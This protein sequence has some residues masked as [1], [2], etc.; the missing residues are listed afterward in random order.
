MRNTANTFALPPR[1]VSL[2]CAL[3]QWPAWFTGFKMFTLDLAFLSDAGDWPTILVGLVTA[4]F[5]I[6]QLDHGLFVRRNDDYM[7]QKTV[8]DERSWEKRRNFLVTIFLI[9]IAWIMGF[10]LSRGLSFSGYGGGAAFGVFF[11]IFVWNLQG[12]WV[13]PLV[14]GARE[15]LDRFTLRW[16]F[17]FVSIL[18]VIGAVSTKRSDVATRL[19]CVDDPSN[20]SDNKAKAR[21]I[22]VYS[23]GAVFLVLLFASVQLFHWVYLRRLLKTCKTTNQ[24]FKMTRCSHEFTVFLFLYLIAYLSGVNASLTMAIME[25]PEAVNG[26]SCS[27]IH[28][29]ACGFGDRYVVTDDTCLGKPVYKS[30]LVI[31]S[32]GYADHYMA[33]FNEITYFTNGATSYFVTYEHTIP[34]DKEKLLP[35]TFRPTGCGRPGRSK[36]EYNVKNGVV[37][38]VVGSGCSGCSQLISS[39]DWMC[40]YANPPTEIYPSTVRSLAGELPCF[41]WK[42]EFESELCGENCVKLANFFGWILFGFYA[43]VPLFRMATLGLS[44]KS[45]LKAEGGEYEDAFEAITVRARSESTHADFEEVDTTQ[46]LLVPIKNDR[47]GFKSRMTHLPYPIRFWKMNSDDV[48]KKDL[49][50]QVA[51]VTS[52]LS[53]FEEKWWWWKIYLLAERAVLAALVFTEMSVWAAFAVTCLGWLASFYTSPYWE[54]DEDKADLIA[55]GTTLLTVFVACLAETEVIRGDEIVVAVVLNVSALVTVVILIMAVGPRRLIMSI[56]AYYKVK[57]RQLKLQNG[58]EAADAMTE[59]EVEDMTETEFL[60]KSIAVRTRLMRR[61]QDHLVGTNFLKWV[62]SEHEEDIKSIDARQR[63]ILEKVAKQFG[64]TSCWLY[65]PGN[66]RMIGVTFEGGKATEINWRGEDLSLKEGKPI[67]KGLQNLDSCKKI[68]LSCN[69]IY[70]DFKTNKKEVMRL[71][72]KFII[73]NKQDKTTLECVAVK[74]GKTLEWLYDGH[75]AHNVEKFRGI[76]FSNDNKIVGINW[77][78]QGLK[79]QLPDKICELKDLKRLDLRFNDITVEDNDAINEMRDCS[80]PEHWDD[81]RYVRLMIESADV[82]KGMHFVK[83]KGDGKHGTKKTAPCLGHRPRIL[84]LVRP[85]PNEKDLVQIEDCNNPGVFLV[86]EELELGNDLSMGG[87]MISAKQQKSKSNYSGLHWEEKG[88]DEKRMKEMMERLG[89]FRIVPALSGTKGNVSFKWEGSAGDQLDRYITFA[90]AGRV[91][92]VRVANTLVKSEE[93]RRGGNDYSGDVLWP[94]DFSFKMLTFKDDMG[95]K[96]PPP[97]RTRAELAHSWRSGL[98]NWGVS[99]MI[100]RMEDDN[101]FRFDNSKD[102]IILC[103]MARKLGKDVEWLLNGM[104]GYKVDWW[105][106]IFAEKGRVKEIDWRHEDLRGQVPEEILQLDGLKEINFQ[107][108]PDMSKKLSKGLL[109]I[110]KRLGSDCE[111]FDPRDDMNIFEDIIDAIYRMKWVDRGGWNKLGT[112]FTLFMMLWVLLMSTTIGM[113]IWLVNGSF[114]VFAHWNFRRHKVGVQDGEDH[115][116][117]FKEV[118]HE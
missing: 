36:G 12:G 2:S 54:D 48:V 115:N 42:A 4:P 72:N 27:G 44:V 46:K 24:N 76:E 31:H 82:P 14:E 106:G 43:V 8:T 38:R 89:T 68:D 105:R 17:V 69:D 19:E 10:V 25:L 39:S 23:V 75:G 111:F 91:M 35:T 6:L 102:K 99:D 41:S 71:S 80:L 5:L 110:Q 93:G 45:I 65:S 96:G 60:S 86:K 11:V 112:M 20:C 13:L 116:S 74:F 90:K 73:M 70:L 113:H 77:A 66:G 1:S 21:L 52:L 108:N 63:N 107:D 37:T 81:D 85:N 118:H 55:R 29:N 57:K 50:Q 64:K 22:D 103:D 83:P 87:G 51:V 88:K 79:G 78:G 18:Y 62:Q 100:T 104:G 16:G 7:V 56:I 61:F 9:C 49:G 40:V 109:D 101:S 32:T 94:N 97:I 15:N 26:T 3:S 47:F 114:F 98:V 59:K 84:H 34:V 117:R 53:A 30:P 33:E 67:P 58:E 28:H 95:G 92:G